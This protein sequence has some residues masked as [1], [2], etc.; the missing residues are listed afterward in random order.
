MKSLTFIG[1]ILIVIGFILFKV[2]APFRDNVSLSYGI[3]MG[4]GIGLLIGG[5]VGYGSKS[6]AVKRQKK[7]DGLKLKQ[8]ENLNKNSENKEDSGI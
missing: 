1:I 2:Q 7:I 8:A 5:I 4:V 3:L 6:M